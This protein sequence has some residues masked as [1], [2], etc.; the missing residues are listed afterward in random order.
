[1]RR[2]RLPTTKRTIATMKRRI[3]SALHLCK[4]C[5]R[6]GSCSQRCVVKAKLVDAVGA[7][8]KKIASRNPF[9]CNKAVCNERL[10]KT[11]QGLVNGGRGPFC[12]HMSLMLE[13]RR[14]TKPPLR[15]QA[16]Q[17]KSIASYCTGRMVRKF[18]D[19][20]CIIAPSFAQRR[21]PCCP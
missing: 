14:L 4:A 11:S 20:A 16:E 12:A 10:P 21:Q 15:E 9:L 7:A 19:S 5:I 2:Y 17:H 13:G 1:M 6:C 3:G 18:A 8:P